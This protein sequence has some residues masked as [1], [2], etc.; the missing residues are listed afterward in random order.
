M[1]PVSMGRGSGPWEGRGGGARGGL[2]SAVGGGVWSRLGLS[3]WALGQG[4]GTRTAPP[5]QQ[6]PGK[7]RGSR[8]ELTPFLVSPL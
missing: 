3:A 6:Q 2:A 4:A 8:G 7:G 1:V 5:L